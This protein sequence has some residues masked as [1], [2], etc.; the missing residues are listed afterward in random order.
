MERLFLSYPHSTLGWNWGQNAKWAQRLLEWAWDH[1][2]LWK[3][4]HR[5][6]VGLLEVGTIFVLRKHAVAFHHVSDA[7]F[8]RREFSSSC[9]VSG[10]SLQ[11]FYANTME[12]LGFPARFLPFHEERA[13]APA[14]GG[15]RGARPPGLAGIFL[16][17]P[18][19]F[20]SET[21]PLEAWL[22]ASPQL[23]LAKV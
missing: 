2:F 10:W 4:V 15:E 21:V 5:M 18:S 14:H 19:C 22:S 23:I 13:S 9:S 12:A 11:T 3:P 8:P 7:F 17:P 16:P 20:W 6:S 1:L